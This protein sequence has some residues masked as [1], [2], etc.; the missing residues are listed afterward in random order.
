MIGKFPKTTNS[1]TFFS[2]ISGWSS[3]KCVYYNINI[4]LDFCCP[5]CVY[6]SLYPACYQILSYLTISFLTLDTYNNSLW[7][8]FISSDRHAHRRIQIHKNDLAVVLKHKKYIFLFR[9][10]VNNF[11][12]YPFTFDFFLNLMFFRCF[13]SSCNC[14][15]KTII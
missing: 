15:Y 1:S 8:Q 10:N 7:K 11:G 12:L 6:L 2:F 3:L 5:P 9:Y 13:F 4:L 14:L